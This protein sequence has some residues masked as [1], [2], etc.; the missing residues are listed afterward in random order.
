MSFQD[1]WRDAVSFHYFLKLQSFVIMK[2]TLAEQVSLKY[3]EDTSLFYGLAMSFTN[4]L[5]TLLWMRLTGK[6]FSVL[7]EIVGILQIKVFHESTF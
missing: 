5:F 2:F 6:H 7:L 1:S 3:S 4:S